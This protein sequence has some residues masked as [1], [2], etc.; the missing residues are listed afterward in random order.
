MRVNAAFRSLSELKSG[1]RFQFTMTGTE[2][3]LSG[4]VVPDYGA[5]RTLYVCR[6]EEAD[7]RTGNYFVVED[8]RPVIVR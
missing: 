1:D 4:K 2:Y 6:R 8:D 5:Q 7:G 3:V